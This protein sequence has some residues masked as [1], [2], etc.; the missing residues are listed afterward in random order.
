[1]SFT[2]YT[3]FKYIVGL[4]NGT[5]VIYFSGKPFPLRGAEGGVGWGEGRGIGKRREKGG[6]GLISKKKKLKK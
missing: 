4:S 3:S 6:L 1:M 5:D 2:S